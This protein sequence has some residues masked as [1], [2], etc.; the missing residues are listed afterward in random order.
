MV[1][2]KNLLCCVL[3]SLTGLGTGVVL[4][5]LH[6][7]LGFL[8]IPPLGFALK[9]HRWSL[10]LSLL[11]FVFFLLLPHRPTR[12][13]IDLVFP[14]LMAAQMLVLTSRSGGVQAALIASGYL[15]CLSAG[16]E[17][18]VFF[19]IIAAFVFVSI[20]FWMQHPKHS[21]V[22]AGLGIFVLMLCLGA[23]LFLLVPRLPA[24]QP[25]LEPETKPR[26][27]GFAEEV[28]TTGVGGRIS[29]SSRIMKVRCYSKKD[30]PYFP[31]SKLYMRGIALDAYQNGCWTHTLG[32]KDVWDQDDQEE[33]GWTPCQ[34][35]VYQSKKMIYQDIELH[36]SNTAAIF[37]LPDLVCVSLQAG[38]A[39]FHGSARFLKFPETL[40]KYTAIS[41]VLVKDLRELEWI[42]SSTHPLGYLKLP[43]KFDGIAQLAR[44][45]V[46]DETSLIRKC[47]RIER[48]LSN[49]CGYSIMGLPQS[50]KDPVEVF[51]FDHRFGCCADFA[52]AMIVM[53]R[54]L[55][56]PCRMAS[57]FIS[58]ERGDLPNEFIMR[59]EHAHAWVEVFLG[60]HGWIRFDP[61][62]TTNSAWTNTGA[63]F[64]SQYGEKERA[65]LVGMMV[66]GAK[67]LW[68][69]FLALSF[70][71]SLCVLF[72]KRKRSS[73]QRPKCKADHFYKQFLKI[74]ARAGVRRSQYATPRELARAAAL[75]LP[76]EPVHT[77]TE[78][79]CAARYGG[80]L[81]DRED[82][83]RLDN[84][85]KDLS[86]P[87][88]PCPQ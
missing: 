40:M 7:G 8:L 44:E 63:S 82:L 80:L 28:V 58:S 22:K 69:A 29:D 39:D 75:V 76:P 26:K 68:P 27:T 15:V 41:Q 57:G 73:V 4:N 49:R 16:A 70:L 18:S 24:P 33:D 6:M 62:P 2:N 50:A 48:F 77:I 32:F 38:L 88:S 65:K 56:I 17:N 60:P 13:G 9:K 11:P 23:P 43:Q 54:T 45:V 19:F 30:M 85:L 81:M 37:A 83:R 78:L 34:T 66:K 53:L 36:P 79:F 86:A 42:Q 1:V 5:S 59:N 87:A 46:G 31:A 14:C 84:A 61:S 64:F 12:L 47:Q 74:A 71:L 25:S 35:L 55:K 3:L 72:R 52:S 67:T 51:L 20:L 21:M 10:C